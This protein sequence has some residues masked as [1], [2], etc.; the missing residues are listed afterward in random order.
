MLTGKTALITGSSSGI[1]LGV[2]RSFV[3]H[4]AKVV[5][6]SER[7]RGEVPAVD[8]AIYIQ[9][10]LLRDDEAERL[11]T[12]SWQALG[13]IDVVVNN[14]GTFRESSFLELTREQFDFIFHFNVWSA[15]A[16]TQAV[17]RRAVATSR[18]GR[19]LFSSSLNATR[20]EPGHTLY[21]ASK[22]AINALV[23]QLA[24]ELAPLGFTTAAVAPGLVETPL[25]DFG[26]RSDPAGRRAIVEQIPLRRIATV[27]DVAEWYAFLASD[28]A[29]YATGTIITV[30]GGLD[31][32]Q[33]ANRP[34]AKNE[35]SPHAP[36]EESSRGA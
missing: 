33:L 23:R 24:I 13:S 28:R 15:I 2:A 9:A 27:E 25:T 5:V 7:A 30:D 8:G 32:Q 29:A 36:R 26:L 12:E 31:A 4:G 17:V 6:T 21:D 22:G 34:I 35:C 14:L 16:V 18:G 1:G 11:V 20:S 19:I 3:A 10:D